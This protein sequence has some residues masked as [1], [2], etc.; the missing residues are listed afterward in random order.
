[1]NLIHVIAAMVVVFPAADHCAPGK[2]DLKE[3]FLCKDAHLDEQISAA[4]VDRMRTQLP[5]SNQALTLN[6]CVVLHREHECASSF[7]EDLFRSGDVPTAWAFQ[8]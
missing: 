1:M 8:R 6:G 7:P 2:S 5:R 4:E 3:R